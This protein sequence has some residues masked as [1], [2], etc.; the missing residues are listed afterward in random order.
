MAG[1]KVALIVFYDKDNRILL[2]NRIG[3]AKRG[4]EWGF[5]GGG[6]E[7]GE[8]PEQSVVR[9]TEEELGYKLANFEYIGNYKNTLPDGF[10]IDRHIFVS[11]LEDKF[12][13]FAQKEGAGM[14]LFSI[15][16][17]KRLKMVS[18]DYPTLDLIAKYLGVAE[19]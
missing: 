1:R 10:T 7:Q 15:E 18:G 5:F 19:H 12:S 3:K 16:E 2:Q 4:E 11:P 9:E 17:A 13:K 14:Q 8:T 6:I